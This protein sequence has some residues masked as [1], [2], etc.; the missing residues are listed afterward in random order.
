MFI[1]SNPKMTFACFS[2]IQGIKGYL[3]SSTGSQFHMKNVQ[4][5]VFFNLHKSAKEKPPKGDSR[6]LR[7]LG[8]TN[9]LVP[10]ALSGDGRNFEISYIRYLF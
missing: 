9:C 5:N 10:D 3:E 8:E 4:N 7:I 2:V 1:F 6:V